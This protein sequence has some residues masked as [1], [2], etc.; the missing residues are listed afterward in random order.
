MSNI[1]I[2]IPPPGEIPYFPEGAKDGVEYVKPP[3]PPPMMSVA[4][5]VANEA[6]TESIDAAFDDAMGTLA[7]EVRTLPV[8]G[9]AL[10]QVITRAVKKVKQSLKV[11]SSKSQD[12]NLEH[13]AKL[14]HWLAVLVDAT[15]YWI[16][17]FAEEVYNTF[18]LLRHTVMPQYVA[19]QLAPLRT[20]LGKDEKTIGLLN[21]RLVKAKQA[22]QQMAPQIRWPIHAPTFDTAVKWWTQRFVQLWH[23][24]Y[25]NMEKRLHGAEVTIRKL[26]KQVHALQTW[27]EKVVTPTLRKHTAELSQLLPLL[28]LAPLVAPIK[29]LL[30][31]AQGVSSPATNAITDNICEP[32][33]D[34]AANKLTQG[35]WSKWAK[36]LFKLL[37]FGALDAILL[38]DLCAM[39]GLVGDIID[40]AKP[41][42]EEIAGVEGGLIGIGCVSGTPP[43][44]APLY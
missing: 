3:P 37:L 41:A 2:E 36:D 34:C 31:W 9:P 30:S 12:Q 25:T 8:F 14:L 18:S 40:L 7:D 27:K 5:G 39:V 35:N 10:A 19:S 28:A 44:P 38:A 29:N 22:I 21:K 23:K 32:V 1:I 6:L 43:L 4:G 26:L 11:G 33:G 15:A 24:V 42:V 13:T 16:G 20:R 17:D